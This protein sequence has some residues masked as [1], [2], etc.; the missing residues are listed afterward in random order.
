[1]EV[2]HR[3]QVCV[4]RIIGGPAGFLREVEER[5]VVRV[6]KL[7]AFGV[8]RR[9]ARVEL[10]HVVLGVD[11]EHRIGR[12]LAAPPLVEGRPRGVA[13]VH[14]D[15]EPHAF[16]LITDALDERHEL[17]ADEQHLGAR[18]AEHVDDFRRSESPVHAD[19]HG[20][21]LE[22]PVDHFEERVG[23]HA[24]VA[25]ACLGPHARGDQ[26]VRDLAGPGVELA[27]RR[28]AVLEHVRDV[29]R[30]SPG[31]LAG[32]VGQYLEVA[33]IEHACLLAKARRR[34]NAAAGRHPSASEA[35]GLIID[36]LP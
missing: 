20:V 33:E 15:H 4:A 7:N 8:A 31:L 36:S 14:G 30:A 25:D 24:D 17:G 34:V 28:R 19:E 3:D 1:V 11:G 35:A 13:P 32:K 26:A 23:V 18:V 2:R 10:Q 21:G 22:A 6:G 29:A 16:E 27:E 5:D 12:V 9:A